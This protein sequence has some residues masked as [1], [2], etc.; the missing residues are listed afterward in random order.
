MANM[1]RDV[2][3]WQLLVASLKTWPN[4]LTFGRMCVV[5]IL[6]LIYPFDWWFTD[7]S[8]AVLFALAGLTDFLD[9]YLARKFDQ[10][11]TFGSLMD[12]I[13]D[14][15]LTAVGLLL[16]ASG[17]E[18][19]LILAGL[20][21]ARDIAV[22]GLR[23]VALERGLRIEVSGFG[24]AKTVFQLIGMSCLFVSFPLW[25]LPWRSV[26]MSCMWI[27]LVLS[28]YSAWIYARAF[29][30]AVRCSSQDTQQDAQD[31]QDLPV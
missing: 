14:K 4:R 23:M 18:L 6:L 10:V 15:M 17:K 7:L 20:L 29:A 26:G 21:L 11:S 8:C 25:S 9:G 22:S 1:K 24:K 12:P 19:P 5:P 13:A 28:G 2:Q 30:E 27:T 31:S 16:L 3:T